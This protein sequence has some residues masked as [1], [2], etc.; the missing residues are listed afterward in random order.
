MA[1][2]RCAH[3]G[4]DKPLREYH[5]NCKSPDGRLTICKPC[6]N[7]ESRR[8]H[9]KNRERDKGYY[10]RWAKD[11]PRAGMARMQVRRAIARGDLALGP[12]EVCGTMENVEFHHDDYSKPLEIRR[13]CRSDHKQ[14]HARLAEVEAKALAAG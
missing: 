12:C 3:C 2:K 11:H 6:A 4:K 8:R 9:A 10:S 13:L 7:A 1:R 14:H 5:R